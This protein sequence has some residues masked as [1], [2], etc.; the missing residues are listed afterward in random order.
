MNREIPK[1]IA[2]FAALAL[3]CA[4][5]IFAIGASEPGLSAATELWRMR[6]ILL[7][8][9]AALILTIYALRR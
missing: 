7:T 6:A 4:C 8:G 5:G 1:A 3:Y 9:T 2:I